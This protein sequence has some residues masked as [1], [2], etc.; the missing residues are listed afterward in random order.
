MILVS[1]L[2]WPKVPH[3]QAVAVIQQL[4]DGSSLMIGAVN[5]THRA[6]NEAADRVKE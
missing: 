1:G 6:I 2:P 3:E 4:L 5:D